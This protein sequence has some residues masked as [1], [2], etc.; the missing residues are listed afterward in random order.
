MIDS[1]NIVLT[2]IEAKWDRN[3]CAN[4]FVAGGGNADYGWSPFKGNYS[5]ML[6]MAA[7]GADSGQRWNSK[8][9]YVRLSV[10]PTGKHV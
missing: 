8:N 9:D 7:S 6:G 10:N 4:I 1:E 2:M 3:N 5:F